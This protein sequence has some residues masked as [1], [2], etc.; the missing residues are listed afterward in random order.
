[1]QI[2]LMHAIHGELV[3]GSHGID[4]G[5]D[6]ENRQNYQQIIR[7]ISPTELG[8]TIAL[9]QPHVSIGRAILLML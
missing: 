7:Q 2:I 6:N 3:R 5:D 4:W 1:M 9:L 8:K